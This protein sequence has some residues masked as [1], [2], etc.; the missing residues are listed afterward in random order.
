[1][2]AL[3]PPPRYPI[4]GPYGASGITGIVPM[5]ETNNT[6]S[7]PTGSEWQFLV[8]EGTYVLKEDLQLATPPPHPSEAPVVNP[9]PLA[10]DPQPASVGTKMTL[11][12]IQSRPPP[13]VHREPPAAEPSL[14]AASCS[15]MDQYGNARHSTEGGMNSED[16]C[17]PSTSDAPNSTTVGSSPAFGEGNSLLVPSHVKDVN[18]RKKPKNNV[19]KSNSSFISRVIVNESL[20]R[21]ITDRP[22]DGIFAFA[23]I[24]RAFQWL[25][26]SSPN[27]ANYFTK[28]LFTKAH[29]LCH[30]VNM[31]TKGASH[32]DVVMGFSTGEI[33]WWEPISQRYTRM[34]KNG[35]INNTP[36]SHIEWIPGSENLFLAAHMDGSLVVYDKEKDDGQFAPEEDETS[37]NGSESED[38][39]NGAKAGTKMHINKSVHSQNQKTNPV[40]A[41]KISNQ[42]INAF[43]FS[44]DNRHLAVVSEDGTL[45]LIDYLEEELLGLF[46]SYYGGLTCVCWTPDGKYVLT[47]GQDDL[48]SIWSAADSALVARCQGHQSWV[49]SLAFDL[50]RCDERTYRFGSVGEDGRLCLW[51][52][53][54]GML[55]RPKN[56]MRQRGSISDA[57]GALF[58]GEPLSPLGLGNGVR[59]NPGFEGEDEDDGVYHTVEPRSRIPILPPVL[60]TVIDTHPA[61]WLDFTEE[62][63]ITSCKDGHIRTWIRPGKSI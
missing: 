63:I 29:C 28:I 61:C 8:G 7:T 12:R 51:D 39:Q 35:V 5:I 11:V 38:G 55:H 56:S 37:A 50:W 15:G 60:N 17:A 54:V 21:R 59:S 40:A 33:I 53:N 36:V 2:F 19:T 62:A 23:N 16:G 49:S 44:P 1:M 6:L 10:T 4:G 24:N 34:N 30:D 32:I 18:K 45:R 22:G 3:P 26:L 42:R 27:K 14:G 52:F 43:A 20:S 57:S 47:G 46:F 41:W 31:V 48:I 58:R 25:D 13:F 9:N